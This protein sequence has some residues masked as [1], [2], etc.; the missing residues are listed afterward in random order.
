MYVDGHPYVWNGLDAGAD[1]FT[2]PGSLAG[3]VSEVKWKILHEQEEKIF[4]YPNTK[5]HNNISR[6]NIVIK[7]CIFFPDFPEKM[8][9]V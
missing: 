2:L 3:L 4:Q 9:V 5:Y 8:S 6:T 1:L 7:I